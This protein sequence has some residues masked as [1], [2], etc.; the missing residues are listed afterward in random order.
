MPFFPHWRVLIEIRRD[1]DFSATHVRRLIRH[2]NSGSTN[3]QSTPLNVLIIS[4][5]DCSMEDV[6]QALVNE[7][8][9]YTVNPCVSIETFHMFSYVFICL[10]SN[11]SVYIYIYIYIYI[12]VYA[13]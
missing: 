13:L 9:A 4:H 1:F 6:K 10:V 5:N 12:S 11:H 3:L 7:L 2:V 8:T